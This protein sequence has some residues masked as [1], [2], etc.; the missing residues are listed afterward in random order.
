[1]TNSTII[2]FILEFISNLNNLYVYM[3]HVKTIIST[4]WL[5]H[6]TPVVL[7]R[8]DIVSFRIAFEW[9][10]LYFFRF[11]EFTVLLWSH[12]SSNDVIITLYKPVFLVLC[13]FTAL[14]IGKQLVYL[15]FFNFW[16]NIRCLFKSN[17]SLVI[18]L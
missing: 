5:L 9:K 7:P 4:G 16:P 13:L 11:V 3:H 18:T 14:L 1:M 17:I 10:Q 6:L 12:G 15:Y 8:F 2:L